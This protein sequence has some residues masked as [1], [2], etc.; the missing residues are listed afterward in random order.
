M[1]EI[2]RRFL[3]TP[4]TT[5]ME[6]EGEEDSPRI[7]EG[8]ACLFN[9]RAD[10]GWFTESI[11][12]GAFDDV[13][14]DDVRALFNHDPNQPLARSVNGEGTLTLSLDEKGL[15][16][17]FE[18]G[19]QSYARDLVESIDRGDVNQSS[20]A[21]QIERAE[22]DFSEELDQ[23]HRTITKV[24][25]LIDVSPVT[26][27]AYTQTEVSARSAE[28]VFNERKKKTGSEQT[29]QT[30]IDRDIEIAQRQI[31]IYQLKQG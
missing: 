10:L 17:R 22:W 28:S 16:Y 1:E 23:E 19:G 7:I 11:A 4:V 18:V 31:D 6:N 27:P 29:E 8:Y 9:E 21:F 24:S 13:M 14:N 2:E 25:R 20:F 12:P 26:Y 30:D 3:T 15:K 5:R